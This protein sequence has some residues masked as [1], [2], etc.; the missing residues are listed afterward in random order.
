MDRHVPGRRDHL[1][2]TTQN[3]LAATSV[4]A[5]PL[6]ESSAKIRSGPPN[7]DEDDH[8]LGTWEGV[9]PVTTVLGQPVADDFT[10]QS[11][12][13]HVSQLRW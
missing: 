12:P 7:D 1:R 11:V 13:D 2:P 3:E 4:M 10:R 5:L 6:D 8:A 9:V